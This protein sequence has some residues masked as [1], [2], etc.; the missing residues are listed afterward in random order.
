MFCTSMNTPTRSGSPLAR[1]RRSEEPVG[2]SERRW[3]A[4]RISSSAAACRS[5]SRLASRRAPAVSLR[6]RSR[7]SVTGASDAGSI[8]TGAA[9][10]VGSAG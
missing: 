8:V 7:A 6:S 10:D 3:I 2:E 9:S 1:V 4:A 5:I